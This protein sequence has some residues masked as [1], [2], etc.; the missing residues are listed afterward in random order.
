MIRVFV[1][2][3]ADKSQKYRLE[4]YWY[5]PYLTPTNPSWLAPDLT[6]RIFTGTLDLRLIFLYKFIF[7]VFS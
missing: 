5:Q 1:A 2:A 3:H 6:D 4:Y 7:G